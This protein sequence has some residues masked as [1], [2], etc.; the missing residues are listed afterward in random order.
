M[1]KYILCIYRYNSLRLCVNTFLCI[2]RYNS[3]RL[4]VNT[5]CVYTDITV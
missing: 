5:F 1:C 2:Y 3:L 4:C